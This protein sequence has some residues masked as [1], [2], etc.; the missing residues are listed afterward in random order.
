[1]CYTLIYVSNSV[2]ARI[3]ALEAM[4]LGRLSQEKIKLTLSTI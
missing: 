4:Y 3:H 1:M 2:V